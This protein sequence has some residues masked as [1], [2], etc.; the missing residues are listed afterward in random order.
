MHVAVK[1]QHEGFSGGDGNV[2]YLDCV[3]VN[4]LVL[5]SYYSSAKCYH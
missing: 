2:Q 4:N 5:M 3:F 1:G